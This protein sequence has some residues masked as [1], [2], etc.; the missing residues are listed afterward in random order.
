MDVLVGG[1]HVVLVELEVT[2]DAV[3]RAHHDA[4]QR[5]LLTLVLHARRVQRLRRHHV[6]GQWLQ[7]GLPQ[8]CGHTHT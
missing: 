7:L 4:V 3:L 6:E 5:A 1:A 8:A 2:H